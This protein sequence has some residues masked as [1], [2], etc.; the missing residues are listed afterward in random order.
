MHCW[1]VEDMYQPVRSSCVREW[2]MFADH[3]TQTVTF[4]WN[5][6]RILSGVTERTREEKTSPQHRKHS[7]VLFTQKLVSV[8]L[9]PPALPFSRGAI[10]V[11]HLITEARVNPRFWARWKVSR[12]APETPSRQQ[13]KADTLWWSCSM[14]LWY[15]STQRSAGFGWMTKFDRT[16]QL[17]PL[18]FPATQVH[19]VLWGL[20]GLV[21]MR[22]FLEYTIPKGWIIKVFVFSLRTNSPATF[23][24]FLVLLFIFGVHPM[25]SKYLYQFFFVSPQ[26]KMFAFII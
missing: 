16:F 15:C 5:A 25:F 22:E 12:W 19:N 8:S 20:T 17:M 26:R 23:T 2:M 14:S 11:N 24:Y 21:V 1:P 3:V 6:E 7:R 9:V 13:I 18:P 4:G 10:I